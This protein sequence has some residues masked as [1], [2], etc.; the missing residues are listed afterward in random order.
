MR[1][2]VIRH[3]GTLCVA[4]SLATQRTAG[5][6]ASVSEPAEVLRMDRLVALQHADGFVNFEPLPLPPNVDRVL[7]VFQHLGHDECVDVRP[8]FSVLIVLK[9]A[10]QSAKLSLHTRLFVHLPDGGSTGFLLRLHP[11]SWHDPLV[12]M[13]TAAN[14]QHLVLFLGSKTQTRRSS[15]E[16]LAVICPGL[17]WFKLHHLY[18]QSSRARKRKNQQVNK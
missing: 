13:P 16:P 6:V 12:W 3:L 4:I 1:R 2:V 5:G 8:V 15:L 9:N 10:E 7:P 17:V 14:Q 18:Y 11:T